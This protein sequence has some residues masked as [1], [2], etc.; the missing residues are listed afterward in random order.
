MQK[1]GFVNIKSLFSLSRLLNVLI[2]L[3]LTL[4]SCGTNSSEELVNSSDA[5]PV[6]PTLTALPTDD[7]PPTLFPSP[8][9][10]SLTPVPLFPLGNLRMIY[11]FN[12]NLYIQNNMESPIQLTNSGKED[13]SPK[14][15]SDGEKIIFSR[16]EFG[17]TQSAGVYILSMRMEVKSSC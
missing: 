6:F 16:R 8:T 1:D 11:S 13:F 5:T 4:A 2:L 17:G 12:G 3:V 7:P 9:L 10:A 14:F 15:F